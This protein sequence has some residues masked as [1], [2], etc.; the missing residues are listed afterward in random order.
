M[1]TTA[2]GSW[3]TAVPTCTALAPAATSWSASS[4]LSTPP[5][6][7][8]GAVGSRPSRIAACTCQMQRTAI[9][10]IAGP[11]RPPVTPASTGR[12]VTVSIT[13]PS[14]VLIIARPS[15]PAASTAP[16]IATSR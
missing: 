5:T 16:A 14:V 3:N 8:I 12:I 15:A 10:R 7:T 1:R 9:G 2:P 4:A 6:P 11:D 13:M